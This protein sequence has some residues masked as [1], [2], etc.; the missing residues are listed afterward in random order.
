MLHSFVVHGSFHNDHDA[1][2]PAGQQDD[3]VLE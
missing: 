3:I 1:Q 2:Q